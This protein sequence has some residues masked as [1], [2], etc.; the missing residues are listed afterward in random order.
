MDVEVAARPARGVHHLLEDEFQPAG[1]SRRELD[2]LRRIGQIYGMDW[3]RRTLAEF[4]AALGTGVATRAALGF[5]IRQLAKLLPV[6]GQTIT[7]ASSAAM[8]F[9]VTFA[10]GRSA[11]YFLAHRHRALSSAGTAEAYKSA[12]SEALSM[13][14]SRRSEMSTAKA[15]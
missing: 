3:D 10:V 5:G 9:A 7:A 6:Y 14:K 12:L 4:S 13:A 2:L 11:A 15:E 8:S 1:V